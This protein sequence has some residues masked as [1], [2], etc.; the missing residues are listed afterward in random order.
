MYNHIYVGTVTL[1]NLSCNLSH[2]FAAPLKHKLHQKLGSVT[3]TEM[4]LSRNDFV[5][6][7]VI[8]SNVSIFHKIKNTYPNVTKDSKIQ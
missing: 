6:V 8:N 7:I 5:A 2:N 1:N 4:H 3:C